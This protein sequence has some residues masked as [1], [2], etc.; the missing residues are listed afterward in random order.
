MRRAAVAARAPLPATWWCGCCGG[1]TP[2]LN[3]VP[4]LPHKEEEEKTKREAEEKRRELEEAEK[5]KEEAEKKKMLSKRF[6]ELPDEEPTD[7]A[8]LTEYLNTKRR[9][10]DEEIMKA[11]KTIANFC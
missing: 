3:F 8:E 7:T 5:A 9:L 10:L 1:T 2:F 4:A 6:P 11:K